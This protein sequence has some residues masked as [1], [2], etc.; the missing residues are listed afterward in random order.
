MILRST[1]LSIVVAA[2]AGCAATVQKS[3]GD[4]AG[5]RIAPASARQLVL[6]VTGARKV[7]AAADWE[8]FKGEWRAALKAKAES[9]GAKMAPQEGEPR[10]TGEAGTLIVV[11]VADYRYLSTGARYGFGAFTGNAFIDAKVRFVDLA[12]G[13]ALGERAYN[14]SSSAWQG[15]FA[16]MTS[17]QVDAICE[18][19]VAELRPR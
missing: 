1:L 7:T 18:E 14:T 12:S 4:T 19:I 17:K 3:A 10:P 6:N 16:P 13:K 2:L 11:D 8:Q 15:V 9:A 5:A